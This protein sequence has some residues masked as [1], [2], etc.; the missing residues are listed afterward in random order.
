LRHSA[1]RRRTVALRSVAKDRSFGSAPPR[2]CVR[3]SRPIAARSFW[4]PEVESARNLAARKCSAA[5]TWCGLR[6][7]LPFASGSASH[8]V[9][10]SAPYRLWRPSYGQTQKSAIVALVGEY[11]GGR[12]DERELEVTSVVQL[13]SSLFV[14]NVQ[15][16]VTSPALKSPGPRPRNSFTGFIF[17]QAWLAES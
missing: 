16:Q 6:P 2:F 13:G 8:D 15:D 17:N 11:C 4:H 9:H 5:K 10:R 14:T 3:P 7:P 12:K 1:T